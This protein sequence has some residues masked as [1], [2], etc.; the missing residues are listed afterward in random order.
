MVE[1]RIRNWLAIFFLI[2]VTLKMDFGQ[3]NAE[4]GQKMVNGQLL[5]LALPIP[6]HSQARH[7]MNQ[8]MDVD[9]V[10]IQ[11]HYRAPQIHSAKPLYQSRQ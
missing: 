7:A 9:I 8:T 11:V 1:I 10:I 6:P 5:F 3:P 4:I 2:P